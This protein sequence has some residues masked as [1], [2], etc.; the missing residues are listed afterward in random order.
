MSEENAPAEE[1]EE[2]AEI[3]VDKSHLMAALSYISFLFLV[4]LLVGNKKDEFISFHLRQGIVLFVAG[5]IVS[6]IFWI[7]FIGLILWLF[8]FFFSSF[9]F[10]QALRNKK[11]KLPYIGKYAEKINI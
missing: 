4:P 8:V 11:W 10:I 6:F 5:V 7:P 2:A 1:K 3:W 9:G